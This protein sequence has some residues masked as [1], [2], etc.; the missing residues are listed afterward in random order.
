MKNVVKDYV[1]LLEE[2][3]AGGTTANAFRDKYIEL[4]KGEC[5]ELDDLVYEVLEG[6]FGDCDAFSDDCSL[7][8]QN[9]EF[10][11]DELTLKKKVI[12]CRDKLLR[13]I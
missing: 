3:I 12:F 1:N 6:I 13:L 8:L 5:R 10:Y 4:F 11:I 7:I 9:P 2:F